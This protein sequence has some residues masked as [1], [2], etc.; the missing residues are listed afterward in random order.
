MALGIRIS[1]EA[2]DNLIRYVK[3][4][5]EKQDQFSDFRDKLESIDEA[6]AKH[7]VE[8]DTDPDCTSRLGAKETQTAIKV[9][10]VNSE[11]DSIAAYL[12]K[13]FVNHTPLFPVLSNDGNAEEAAALQA[14]IAKDARQQR[15]GGQLLLFLTKAARYNVSAI[16]VEDIWQKDV[17][18]INDSDKLNRVKVDPVSSA[19]TR[20]NAMDMYNLLFDYRVA[21]ADVAVKGDYVGYNTLW[22]KMELKKYGNMLSVNKAGYNLKEAYASGMQGN[23]QYWNTPP[24]VTN[25]TQTTATDEEDWFNWMGILDKRPEDLKLANSSYF[26][27]RLYIRIIPSEFKIGISAHPTII[28]LTVINLQYIIE[29]EEIVTPLDV[30]PILLCDLREDGFEYQTKSAGENVLPYQETATE[31]LN[32]RLEGSKRAVSDRAIYDPM[33]L[34]KRDVNSTISAAKIPIKKKLLQSGDNKRLSDTYYPIPFDGQGVV[35]AM[36]DLQTILKLKDDINGAN[37]AFRGQQTPGNRTLGEFDT[38][39]GAADDKALPSALRVEEQVM[40]FIK[41]IVKSN[42][43]KSTSIEEEVLNPDTGEVV[44]IDPVKLRASLMDFKLADG[45]RPK[46]A[47]RD[48]NVLSTALQ[49]VQNSPELNEQYNVGD[50]FADVMGVLD[51]DISKHRREA[52]GSI[53]GTTNQAQSTGAST[54]GGQNT[55]GEAV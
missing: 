32:V 7:R 44:K 26:V 31:L 48:P 19:V 43:L 22:S 40:I 21:P 17:R 39:S 47:I 1:S 34:D 38:L 37:F 42:I 15:W 53:N 5:Q 54:P 24:D 55:S 46:T 27:T 11:A 33:Y 29:Y 50:I 51:I 28:K 52:S 23:T 4:I 8:L 12:A 6:Y 45:L 3:A 41:L 2:H 36:T 10:I 20:L 49:V 30:L 9:P 13:I 35:N 18:V 25:I 16:E 14:L